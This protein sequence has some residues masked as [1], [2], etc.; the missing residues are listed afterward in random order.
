MDRLCKCGCG[1]EIT[2]ARKEIIEIF[3][4][5][6]HRDQQG[7]THETPEEYI[8]WYAKA[9]YNCRVVWDYELDEFENEMLD[10]INQ[11]IFVS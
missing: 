7:K 1:R 9:D 8:A 4:S 11:E 3:G 5:Y 6:H 2:S 10:R